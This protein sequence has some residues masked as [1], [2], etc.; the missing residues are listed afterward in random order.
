MH[1][2][3]RDKRVACA[4]KAAGYEI[5]RSAITKVLVHMFQ[6]ATPIVTEARAKQEDLWDVLPRVQSQIDWARELPQPIFFELFVG[7]IEARCE[8]EKNPEFPYDRY[9]LYNPAV[10]ELIAFRT[11]VGDCDSNNMSWILTDAVFFNELARGL[12]IDEDEDEDVMMA[13]SNLDN[14]GCP[15]ENEDPMVV[16]VVRPMANMKIEQEEE[17]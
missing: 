3:R 10:L 5:T 8:W 9:E 13:D 17:L 11:S 2:Q 6:T 16:D 12:G 7:F 1:N 15:A 14:E 4:L